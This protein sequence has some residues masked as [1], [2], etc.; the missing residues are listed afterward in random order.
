[1]TGK[2]YLSPDCYPDGSAQQKAAVEWHRDRQVQGLGRPRNRSVEPVQVIR[3][4]RHK[5]GAVRTDVNGRSYPSKLEASY[6]AELH[7]RR[8]AGEIIGWLE[9][10]PLRLAGG[11]TYQLDF[12]IFEADGSVR[13][14]ETKG[15]ETPVW[16]VK[17]K[18]VAEAYP[19][20]LV[21]VVKKPPKAKRPR[22]K[23]E[24]AR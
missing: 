22:A 21:E 18:L 11:V 9:Q 16:R 13:A 1:M 19:W 10:V 4:V 20:L 8:L 12:L 5:F 23:K 15:F 6:A 17:Q 24:S 2:M 7:R 3:A 14:V